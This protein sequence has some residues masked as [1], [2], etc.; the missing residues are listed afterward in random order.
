MTF[1][2]PGKS[3]QQWKAMHPES[4]VN[5]G[6]ERIL[7]GLLEGW[8]LHLKKF[9]CSWRFKHASPDLGIAHPEAAESGVLWLRADVVED[10]GQCLGRSRLGS[11]LGQE[12]GHSILNLLTCLCLLTCDNLQRVSHPVGTLTATLG[13]H[14]EFHQH[15]QR[16][17]FQSYT[18]KQHIHFEERDSTQTS[19]SLCGKPRVVPQ[20]WGR[21][22]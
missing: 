14:I 11:C 9:K 20:P 8:M 19:F 6:I 22:T 17:I 21:C 18:W 5:C 2:P 7:C 1:S 15:H 10:A 3:Q 16:A 13:T 4:V 12:D